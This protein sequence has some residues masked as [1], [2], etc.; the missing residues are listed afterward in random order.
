MGE[1]TKAPELMAKRAS[2]SKAP[3]LMAER[4]ST[5]KVPELMAERASTSKAPELMAEQTSTS[6]TFVRTVPS[7]TLMKILLRILTRTRPGDT[8]EKKVTHYT[9]GGT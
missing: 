5:S 3:E 2:R 4:A 8:G 1:Q 6:K 9:V 7:I